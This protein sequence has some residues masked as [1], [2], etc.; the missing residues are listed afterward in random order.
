MGRE[1]CE[2]LRREV[3]AEDVQ[4]AL[5]LRAGLVDLMFRLDFRG[6]TAEHYRPQLM[7]EM[8]AAEI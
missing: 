1:D 3:A 4:Q 6:Q 2:A 7:A 5:L 8:A